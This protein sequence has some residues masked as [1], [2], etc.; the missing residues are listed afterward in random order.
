MLQ[1]LH[2]KHIEG[3]GGNGSDRYR[4]VL[5]DI[6]HFVQCMLGTQ[7]N[8]IIRDTGLQRGSIVRLRQYTASNYKGKK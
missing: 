5:S 1:C 3:K 6:R 4:I 8:P 2:V 7:A